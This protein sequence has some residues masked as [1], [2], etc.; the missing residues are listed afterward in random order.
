MKSK[1]EL[2]VTI[3]APEALTPEP[4][5]PQPTSIS[6]DEQ[7]LAAK[8]Q[9]DNLRKQAIDTLLAQKREID[10]KLT[11]LGHVTIPTKTAR[12]GTAVAANGT[13]NPCR[14]CGV[15]GHDARSHRKENLA[16]IAK[17]KRAPRK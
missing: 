15:F 5:P 3:S 14:V 16:A 11:R 9:Y 6:V 2:P 7:A 10:V 8:E 1:T 4:T 17:G 13:G 12:T